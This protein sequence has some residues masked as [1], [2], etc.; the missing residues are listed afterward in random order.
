[1]D[2]FKDGTTA[3]PALAMANVAKQNNEFWDAMVYLM[4]LFC[5]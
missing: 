1:M 5:L 4:P 3:L 2:A